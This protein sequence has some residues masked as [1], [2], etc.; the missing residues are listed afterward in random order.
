MDS[1]LSSIDYRSSIDDRSELNFAH[2]L[3]INIPTEERTFISIPNVDE[4]NGDLR[5]FMYCVTTG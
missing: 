3:D 1:L 4:D 2:T 5:E